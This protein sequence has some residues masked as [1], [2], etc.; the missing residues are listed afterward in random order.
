MMK[1]NANERNM[2]SNPNWWEAD[3]F[4]NYKHARGV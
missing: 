2:V 1:E 3:Q 4:A